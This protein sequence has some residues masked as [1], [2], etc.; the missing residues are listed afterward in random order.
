MLKSNTFEENKS[1]LFAGLS[2]EQTADRVR[3]LMANTCTEDELIRKTMLGL[4][5]IAETSEDPV[6]MELV[7]DRCVGYWT[8][9][10]EDH[11]VF[12]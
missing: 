4:L 3:D 2:R 8:K 9:W 1:V 11:P 5:A 7:V 10:N 6:D 12:F